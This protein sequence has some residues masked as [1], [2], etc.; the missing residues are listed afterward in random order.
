[1]MLSKKMVKQLN[2]ELKIE[3]ILNVDTY[4]SSVLSLKY[5]PLFS[6]IS[7]KIYFHCIH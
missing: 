1:M 3:N 6:P 4:L 5:F 7:L 2:K